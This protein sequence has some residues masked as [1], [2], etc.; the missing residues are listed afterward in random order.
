MKNDFDYG[1]LTPLALK[2]LVYGANRAWVRNGGQ[3]SEQQMSVWLEMLKVLPPTQAA[4][5]VLKVIRGLEF[6][7]IAKLVGLKQR[8]DAQGHFKRALEALKHSSVV[9]KLLADFETH[10]GPKTKSSVRI[11][12]RGGMGQGRWARLGIPQKRDP[13]LAE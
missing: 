4:I 2:L 11:R 9:G 10:R 6:V 3:S 5:V 13:K 8:Q 1:E 7:R 12:G